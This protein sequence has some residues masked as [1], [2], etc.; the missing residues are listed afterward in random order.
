MKWSFWLWRQL[1]LFL[2]LWWFHSISPIRTVRFENQIWHNLTNSSKYLQTSQ[3]MRPQKAVIL[4]VRWDVSEQILWP[5]KD[6][7]Q[8]QHRPVPAEVWYPFG[9]LSD[10]FPGGVP[11]EE[12]PEAGKGAPLQCRL[13]GA[14]LGRKWS[15]PATCRKI[16]YCNFTLVNYISALVSFGI[17]WTRAGCQDFLPMAG[18]RRDIK[19]HLDPPGVLQGYARFLGTCIAREEQQENQI[20]SEQQWTLVTALS[21]SLW[22]IMNY[23]HWSA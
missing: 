21:K 18:G 16:T 10:E 9:G 12:T 20:I 1:S 6:L 23:Y 14:K 7:W 17:L 5:R 3:K 22:I 4:Q 2:G 13:R 8:I 19:G 15:I 11:Q